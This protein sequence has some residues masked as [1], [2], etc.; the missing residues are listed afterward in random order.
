MRDAPL[1]LIDWIAEGAPYFAR[2]FELPV[3]AGPPHGFL[4]RDYCDVIAFLDGEGTNVVLDPDGKVREEPITPGTLYF[5]RPQD[6]HRVDPGGSDGLRCVQVGF[7]MAEWQAFVD[8]AD[9]D[10]ARTTG[11]TPPSL[12]FD[13]QDSPLIGL[14]RDVVGA[15]A[16]EASKL[17]LIR[18]WTGLVPLLLPRT[19]DADAR[20]AAPDWLLTSIERLRDEEALRIGVPRLLELSHVSSTHLS[21]TVRRYFGITPSALVEDLRLRRASQLLSTTSASISDIAERCGFSNSAYFST[22]FRRATS[23]SPREY[24]ARARTGLLAPP[25]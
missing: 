15:L 14:F 6:R 20:G 8:L 2:Y 24:R 23:V 1:H 18:F 5:W 3:V 11:A 22:R 7:P 9:I 21:R 13:P 16:G 12:R 25:R 19:E 17:D 10:P 4:R